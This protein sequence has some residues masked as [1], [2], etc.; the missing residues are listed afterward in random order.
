MDLLII[1]TYVAIAWSIFKIFKIPVNKWTVPTAALGGVFIVSALIL[2]MNYNH[3]YTFLAQKAVISIPI[4]PQVTGVVN[5]VTDKANRAS[6]R[7]RCFLLL[8]RRA[9]RRGSTVCRPTW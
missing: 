7:V 9:I 3:P 4:T 2:L 6:K 5:S 1:L 8:T